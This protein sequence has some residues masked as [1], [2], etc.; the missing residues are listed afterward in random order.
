[1]KQLSVSCEVQYPNFHFSVDVDIPTDGVTAIF[2]P[3]GCGKTTFLRC[4]AG[5]ERSKTGRIHFGT[6]VWQDEMQRK[7][8]P[9]ARRPIGYV[10]QEPRLFPHLSVRANLE[11]GLNRTSKIQRKFSNDQVIEILG[12]EHLLDRRPHFLSGGEQQRV[13]MGRALLTSPELLLM[14]E[15]LSSLDVTRKREI[16][17]FIQQ[18]DKE[19][20]LPVIY[21]SHS[22]QEV[23]QLAKTLVLLKEGCV[24]G[25]GPINDVFSKMDSRT[26][27]E[28]S[29]VGAVIDTT[30]EEHDAEFGLTKLG[31][32]GRHVYVP[33]QNQPVGQKLR[34]QILARD[35]SIVTGSPSFQSS[36]LNI[37][38]AMVTEI[39]TVTSATPFVDIKLDIGCPLLATI[40]R[41]SL[42]ALQLQPGQQVYA[43][44][45]AVALRQD[46]LD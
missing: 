20:H 27:M 18:L 45:K 1:M 2:G 24:T 34:V 3:S 7:F 46:L 6:E 23:L 28:E 30:V 36:V 21:V 29:H 9:I 5:L 14:D 26:L 15:P 42:V 41:K 19:L 33:H 4:L 44:I 25:V 43:Q 35:V 13:A 10:F 40:T 12:I 16:L 31:F 11:Y 32:R 38:E 8:V 37:F 17:P 22:L 39:G